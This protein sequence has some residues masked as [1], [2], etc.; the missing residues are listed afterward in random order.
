MLESPLRI[1]V[2]E[3][4]RAA[5]ADLIRMLSREPAVEVV[6]EAGDVDAA[7]AVVAS[8]QPDGLILDVQL[9]TGTGFDVLRKLESPPVVM[10]VT[11]HH[12][13]AVAAFELA[14]IDYLLKPFTAERLRLG[15]DRMRLAADRRDDVR[16]ERLTWAGE[17]ISSAAPLERLYVRRGRRIVVV[18]VA[19]VLRI[20]ADGVYTRIITAKEA[21]VATVPL[22]TLLPLLP[23]TAFLRVHRSHI[24]NLKAVV[25][26][27]A[28]AS[29]RLQVE[30]VN[31][32]TVPC[33]REY[34]RDIRQRTF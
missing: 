29:G 21:H 17:S 12:A 8:T 33:S 3:D 26:F 22:N 9:P 34:A 32:A 16:S 2:V 14:A 1:V 23:Q 6:G 4:E 7:V 10:F 20:E 27:T 28:L 19:D 25:A 30:M 31:G 18:P 5:R 11:A 15:I 13:H 24:V